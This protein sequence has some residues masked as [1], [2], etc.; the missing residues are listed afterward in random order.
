MN[1]L[2]KYNLKLNRFKRHLVDVF[3][4]EEKALI[5]IAANRVTGLNEA[6]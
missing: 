1:N 2:K 3:T 6:T 5:N 4:N